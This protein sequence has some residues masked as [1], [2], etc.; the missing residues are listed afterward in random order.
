LGISQIGAI[1]MDIIDKLKAKEI[2]PQEAIL[3]NGTHGAFL[4]A[5]TIDMDRQPLKCGFPT[6]EEYQYILGNRGNMVVIA[7][8]AGNN[9]TAFSSQIALSASKFGKVLFFSLE[10]SKEAL[11]ERLISV[12][13]GIP[14]KRLGLPMHQE[15]LSRCREELSAYQLKIIDTPNLSINTLLS[16]VYDE[17]RQ[18]KVTLVV[19]DYIGLLSSNKSD[20]RHLDVGSI[21]S[22]IKVKL[23]DKLQIPVIVL[24][25]MNQGIDGRLA[26]AELAKAK[27]NEIEIRP[28]LSDM[29][30]SKKIADS[31]DVVMF[32]RRPCLYDPAEPRDKFL[33]YVC[34]NR[35]GT[36]QDFRLTFKEDQTKFVDTKGELDI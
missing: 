26:M 30:E 24:A 31:A 28:Q 4:S 10:M 9:K 12:M 3:K 22:D 11:A 8:R 15:R 13:S 19:I 25:Q 32:V 5:I 33:V 29:G 21:A 34:K 17:N 23:A 16:M 6:I 20:N 18:E 14:I 1:D 7:G 36:T 35:S 2:T 27:G